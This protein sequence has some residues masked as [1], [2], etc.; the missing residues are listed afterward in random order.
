MGVS[1]SDGDLRIC[2]PA[3]C[4]HMCICTGAKTTTS[5]AAREGDSDVLRPTGERDGVLDDLQVAPPRRAGGR[6]VGWAGRPAGWR[7]D[8]GMDG[9]KVG[10]AVG[11]VGAR[12]FGRMDARAWLGG[13]VGGRAQNLR[14]RS[15]LRI[16]R[17]HRQDYYYYYYYYYLLYWTAAQT[18]LTHGYDP[19]QHAAQHR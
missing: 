8:G 18:R 13:R 2:R 17:R 9:Q 10:R 5:T 1:E 11:Q 15:R 3:I 7:T 19:W 16:G 4:V 6:V 12:A 14:I